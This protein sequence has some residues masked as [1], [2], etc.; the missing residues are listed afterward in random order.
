MD[1]RDITPEERAALQRFADREHM[2]KRAIGRNEYRLPWREVLNDTYWYNARLWEGGEPGDG[3]ILHGIRND[4]G[5]TW[6]HD[7]CDV[8]PTRKAKA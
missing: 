6:L 7:V 8:K 5:P 2:Q 1:Y 4:L 3:S